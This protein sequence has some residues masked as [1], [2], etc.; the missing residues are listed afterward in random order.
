MNSMAKFGFTL[1]RNSEDVILMKPWS[2]VYSGWAK[3]L[4]LLWS[5]DLSTVLLYKSF[6]KQTQQAQKDYVQSTCTTWQNILSFIPE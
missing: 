1:T 6:K 5:V 4:L 2:M 3:W